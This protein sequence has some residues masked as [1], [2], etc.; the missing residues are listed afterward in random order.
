MRSCRCCS[1][2]LLTLACAWLPAGVLRAADPATQPATAPAL[3]PRVEAILDRQEARGKTL[4]DIR[5]DLEYIK[6]DT[7]LESKSVF[8]G[9]LRF[10]QAE[11]NPLFY[12]QF[13]THTEEGIAQNNPKEW[14]VF[15]GRWYV[16]ARESTRN[17]VKH[18]IVAPG[19]KKEVFKLGQGPFPV[20]FGQKKADIIGTFDI[21]WI[22]P[23]PKDPPATDTDHLECKPKPG[24]ELDKRYGAV[25]FWIDKK[26]DLPVRLMTEDKEEDKTITANFRDLRINTGMAGSELN[27]PDLDYAVTEER[28]PGPAAAAPPPGEK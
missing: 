4:Q 1:L 5:C 10:K 26:L 3:D 11:P 12:I 16:E 17:T 8:K 20:P 19:E 7:V 13:D 6:E 2:A 27:L 21:K 22:P 15:D 14:H 25:H 9:E 18:E 28:L 23:G 24:G